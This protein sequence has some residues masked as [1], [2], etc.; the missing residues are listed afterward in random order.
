MKEDERGGTGMYGE[1]SACTFSVT[2]TEGKKEVI[3]PSR[4]RYDNIKHTHTSC[5]QTVH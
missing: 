2:E 1:S 3:K 4:R 5:L